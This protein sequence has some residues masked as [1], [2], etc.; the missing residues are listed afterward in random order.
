MLLIE[1][2][3]EMRFDRSSPS[4]LW[5]AF[6]SDLTFWGELK[7]E[8]EQ[9]IMNKEQAHQQQQQQKRQNL[10][11]MSDTSGSSKSSYQHHHKQPVWRQAVD[12]VT[13]RTY[14]YDAISRQ[15]QWEKVSGSF[16]NPIRSCF[17]QKLTLVTLWKATRGSNDGTTTASTKA[18]GGQSVL[19]ANGT[20]H[21]FVCQ[22]GATHSHWKP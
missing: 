1:N 18:K 13:R 6:L 17:Q 9:I 19:P 2:E 11:Y 22:K 4:V 21:L 8:D 16:M 20:K 12:P 14:Y 7:P 5:N 10:Y 15:T 3:L